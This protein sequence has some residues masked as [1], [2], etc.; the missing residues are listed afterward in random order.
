MSS[1]LLSENEVIENELTK[2]EQQLQHMRY[3][4][5]MD[6]KFLEDEWMQVSEGQKQYSELRHIV[7]KDKCQVVNGGTELQIIES[8]VEEHL[9]VS[10]ENKKI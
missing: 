5:L 2:V 7:L 6:E 4:I 8:L 1:R 3:I 10:V 9:V